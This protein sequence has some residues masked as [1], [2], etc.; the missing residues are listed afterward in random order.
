MLEVIPEKSGVCETEGLV[1]VPIKCAPDRLE[2]FTK[3]QRIVGRRDLNGA[4]EEFQGGTRAQINDLNIILVVGFVCRPSSFINR[5]ARCGADNREIVG[6][7]KCAVVRECAASA[8]GYVAQ[9]EAEKDAA[10]KSPHKLENISALHGVPLFER[11][12]GIACFLY[13]NVARNLQRKPE[14]HDNQGT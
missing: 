1:I 2:R 3:H 12:I 4:M 5:N 8:S 7:T 14:S 11:W 6:N 13:L 10:C 9:H